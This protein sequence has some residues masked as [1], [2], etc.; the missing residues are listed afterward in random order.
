MPR[1]KKFLPFSKLSRHKQRDLYVRLRTKIN[2]TAL[3]YGQNFTSHLLLN[4]PGRP[5]L[6]NQWFDFYFLGLDGV[7]IWNAALCTASQAYWDAIS[8]LVFAEADRLCP[9][10]HED[11]NFK[12]L[13]IPVYD[14]V[15]GKILH[16]LMR[17]P[18]IKAELGNRTLSQFVEDYSAKLIRE[19]SGEA[20]PIFESFQIDKGYQYGVGLLAVMDTP[21][22]NAEAIETMIEKFRA[23]GEQNWENSTPVVRSKLPNDTFSALAKKLDL[24]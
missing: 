14:E 22:I 10:N 2:R 7:T 18:E 24:K 8:D 3:H 16:Y 6:Y 23:I 15:T 20:A 9:K 12:N 21:E 5:A 13:F 17:E 19:D 11:F 1:H 4:E